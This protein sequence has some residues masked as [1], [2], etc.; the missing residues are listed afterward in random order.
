MEVQVQV[1]GRG[2]EEGGGTVCFG[3]GGA[4]GAFFF[5]WWVGEGEVSY[6]LCVEAEG[7]GQRERDRH[8]GSSA[9]TAE[10]VYQ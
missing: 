9:K 1:E 8:L 6:V 3:F 10:V 4:C 2:G 5:D 7:R